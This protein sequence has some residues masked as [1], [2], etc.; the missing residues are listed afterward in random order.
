M[1]RRFIALVSLF[2]LFLT[3]C[4]SKANYPA[5]FEEDVF[6]ND[7]FSVTL[8]F[9]LRNDDL[10]MAGLIINIPKNS[11]SE[12]KTITLPFA[13]STVKPNETLLST[14]GSFNDTTIV[15]YYLS[16]ATYGQFSIGITPVFS[17]SPEAYTNP[18]DTQYSVT[19]VKVG[20]ERFFVYKYPDADP[21]K[22][23]WLQNIGALANTNIDAIGV[24]YPKD[25]QGIQIR[26]TG[27]TAIPVAYLYRNG[28]ARFYPSNSKDAGNVNALEVRYKLSPTQSQ[29]LAQE[30]GLKLLGI[31][32]P[33][34]AK[35]YIDSTKNKK[36]KVFTYIIAGI[37]GIIFIWLLVV[38]IQ[39]WGEA[40]LNTFFDLTLAIVVGLITGYSL[41]QEKRQPETQIEKAKEITEPTRRSS[42]KSAKK[43]R[44]LTPIEK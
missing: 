28:K 35:L 33:F 16:S 26:D 6:A 15:N 32:T 13:S 9:D 21:Y 12:L 3:A 30:Y 40:G 5:D 1:T 37:Q 36:R 31:L 4:A 19:L 10:P 38:A 8:G 39:S 24:T 41:W 44:L 34:F 2:S 18:D 7:Q 11:S 14:Y 23:T 25:A 43:K 20:L 29:K 27:L 22:K 42:N 17:P